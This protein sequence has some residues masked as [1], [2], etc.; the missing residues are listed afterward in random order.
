MELRQIIGFTSRQLHWLYQ[1]PITLA[2]PVANYSNW[3]R[4]WKHTIN[5]INRNNFVLGS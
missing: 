3:L 2:L 5:S 4:V 1:S